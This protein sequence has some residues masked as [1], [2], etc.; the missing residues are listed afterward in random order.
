MFKPCNHI[1]AC[2][3]CACLM[4]RCVQCRSSVE[5]MVPFTVCC[6]GQGKKQINN[7][8]TFFQMLLK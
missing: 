5:S 6:G 3:S 4:K 1:V 7:Y 8:L 2:E